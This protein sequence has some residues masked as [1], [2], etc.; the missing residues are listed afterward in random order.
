MDRYEDKYDKAVAYLTAKPSEI[1][2]AWGNPATHPHGCLFLYVT[3]NG[4]PEFNRNS[5]ACGCLTMIRANLND[6]DAWTP[7]LTEAIRRDANLPCRGS[8]ITPAHLPHFAKWQRRIDLLLN[9]PIE[10]LVADAVVPPVEAQ[11]VGR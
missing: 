5:H 9:R 2:R 7:E 1:Y 6:Y 8:D 11:A 4:L 10:A 3:P